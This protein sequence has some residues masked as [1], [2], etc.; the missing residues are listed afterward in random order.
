MPEAYMFELDFVSR[1]TW[2]VKPFGDAAKR[3]MESTWRN[4]SP[5]AKTNPYVAI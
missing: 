1:K 4:I 5:G 2:P 3:G